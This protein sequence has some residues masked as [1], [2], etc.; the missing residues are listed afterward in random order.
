M[1]LIKLV[2]AVVASAMR[3]IFTT[4]SCVETTSNCSSGFV[5]LGFWGLIDHCPC[6][7]TLARALGMGPA[8]LIGTRMF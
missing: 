7:Q 4:A 2:L 8:R 6:P 3:S 1:V 5:T